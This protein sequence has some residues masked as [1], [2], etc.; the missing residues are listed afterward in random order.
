MQPISAMCWPCCFYLVQQQIQHLQL[1][2]NIIL[3]NSTV[4]W[5]RKEFKKPR[6]TIV[7]RLQHYSNTQPVLNLIQALAS[8]GISSSGVSNGQYTI[9][10]E[11]LIA[12]PIF[13]DFSI[14]TCVVPVSRR[15]VD[16]SYINLEFVISLR[17]RI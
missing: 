2:E 14:S 15:P 11:D 1:A 17:H 6:N 12:F 8:A 5:S 10:L 13:K 16:L 4:N 3:A 7:D 9:N